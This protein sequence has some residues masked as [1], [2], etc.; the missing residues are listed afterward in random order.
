MQSIAEDYASDDANSSCSNMSISSYSLA[1]NASIPPLQYP[2]YDI[3]NCV[4][5]PNISTLHFAKV[6]DHKAENKNKPILLP[7]PF[8]PVLP[9]QIQVEIKIKT[10]KIQV[11]FDEP[12][13][14]DPISA[15]KDKTTAA[16][17]PVS[18]STTLLPEEENPI[19]NWNLSDRLSLGRRSRP[20]VPRHL[21]VTA[22]DSRRRR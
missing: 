14:P 4:E 1:S 16:N 3:P 22:P 11:D 2:K 7:A 21:A 18:E 5:L 17:N 19:D 10:D 13:G 12:A 9:A 8:T 20:G 6:E 15:T